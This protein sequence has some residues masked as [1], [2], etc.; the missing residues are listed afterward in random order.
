MRLAMRVEFLPHEVDEVLYWAQEIEDVKRSNN[1]RNKKFDVNNTDVGVH[2][3]GMLGELAAGRVLGAQPDWEIYLSGD[4]GNDMTAWG[5]TWQ[6][7][8]SSMRKLIFNYESDFVTDAAVLVHH[9]ASKH[10]VFEHPVFEVVGGISR[11]RFMALYYE[12]DF[13]YGVRLVVDADDLIGMETI[14]KARGAE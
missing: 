9:H 1:V 2:A 8:T 14:K 3:I 6:V 7:K 12:H 11:K 10:K 5:L 13:G 4:D